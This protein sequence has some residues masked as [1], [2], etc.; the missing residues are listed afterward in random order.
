VSRANEGAKAGTGFQ[1]HQ[2]ANGRKYGVFVPHSY[3]PSKWYPTILF[4][5]GGFENGSDPDKAFNV[6]IGPV[7]ADKAETFEYIVIFPQARSSWRDGPTE[8][9]D[10]YAA[11][12]ET[13]KKYRVDDARVTLTGLSWGGYGVWALAQEHPTEFCALVPMCGNEKT[14]A[15]PAVKRIPTWC[16]H[17]NLDPFVSAGDSK[18]MVNLINE[19]GGQAKITT[20]GAIGHDVWVRAYKE[21]ELWAWIGKQ[22]KAGTV[23]PA[24]APGARAT[25]PGA[26]ATT[27]VR[28]VT[29]GVRATA[30]PKVI[31][32]RGVS[33]ANVANVSVPW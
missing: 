13:R 11:L 2:L 29:A 30:M 12:Q 3:S 17:N 7:I 5:H 31:P 25:A 32:A 27:G 21:P 19:A 10:A 6:G 23:T 8:T 14:D 1:I 22:R 18:N 4:L 26:R 24:A 33:P 9:N 16:F 28:P 20:Y 15:V